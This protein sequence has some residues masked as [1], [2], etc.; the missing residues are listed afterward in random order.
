MPNPVKLSGI[1]GF[2]LFRGV[3]KKEAVGHFQGQEVTRLQERATG[4]GEGRA[5][6][7]VGAR[8]GVGASSGAGSGSGSGEG[9]LRCGQLSLFL[10]ILVLFLS[11]I[12]KKKKRR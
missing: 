9:P 8:S 1:L 4:P 12:I 10:M 2:L 3:P 11:F 5:R 7:P 6:G